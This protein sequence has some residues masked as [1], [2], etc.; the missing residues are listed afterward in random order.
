MNHGHGLAGFI[1][2][3]N[4]I[5]YM[6]LA[7]SMGSNPNTRYEHEK[8]DCSE[9]V[10]LKAGEIPS[11]IDERWDSYCAHKFLEK[12]APKGIVTIFGGPDIHHD[13]YHD[14]YQMTRDFAR[15]WTESPGSAGRLI[16]TGGGTGI[17]LAATQGAME[18][19]SGTGEVISLLYTFPE[20]VVTQQ[21]NKNNH[22]FVYRTMSKREADLIDYSQAV[23]TEVGGL[24]TN[25]EL[26]ET[27]EKVHKQIK[28]PIPII[29]LVNKHILLEYSTDFL[30]LIKM[31]LLSKKQCG[32]LNLTSSADHAIKLI[33]MSPQARLK[34]ASSACFFIPHE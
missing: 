24:G 30:T 28:D 25:W 17:M 18:A 22:A 6:G 4:L 10:V 14:E 9:V 21:K 15:K 31:N 8:I 33:L 16:A 23:I 29:V 13:E 26:M 12:T 3:L 1:L 2:L 20:A 19:F 11:Y 7:Q 32:L 27:L 5:S 34:D